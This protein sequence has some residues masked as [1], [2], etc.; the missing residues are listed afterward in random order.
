MPSERM[1]LVTKLDRVFS[2]WVRLSAADHTGHVQCYTCGVTK[3]WQKVDAGH[4]MVRGKY[5]TRWDP[6]NVKAQCKGCNLRSGEQHLFGLA[7]DREYGEGT[8]EEIRQQ[9]NQI[10]KWTNQE[11]RDL[12]KHYQG[13]LKNL[14]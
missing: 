8:A 4:F 2:K 11:L 14:E 7:L 3:H 9:S 10:R 13:E 12:I 5:G 1:K 6:R